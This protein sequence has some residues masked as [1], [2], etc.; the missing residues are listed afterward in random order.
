MRGAVPG[1]TEAVRTWQP[2]CQVVV[3]GTEGGLS[4]THLRQV[5]LPGRL[6]AL[7]EGGGEGAGGEL[8]AGTVSTGRT[9]AECA[10]VR[11]AAGV[12]AVRVQPAVTL[13]PL[14]HHGVTAHRAGEYLCGGY[15]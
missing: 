1:V 14:L 7:C 4:V 8:A 13:L 10:G 12:G 6:P 2:R 3:R 5:T 9:R 11:L 15:R